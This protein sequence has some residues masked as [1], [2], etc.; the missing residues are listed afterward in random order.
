MDITWDI[1]T[2]PDGMR[3]VTTPV[4]AAQ[5]V[6]VNVFV[7]AGSR[8]EVSRT[9]GVAHF[10]EHMVFKGTPKRP[11][12]IALAETIEGAGGVLAAR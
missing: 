9:M 6:S 2:L 8:G 5:S 3:V 11:N 12:A 10:L 4:P 1:G 7:G